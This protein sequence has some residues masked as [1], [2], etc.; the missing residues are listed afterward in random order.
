MQLVN[1][2]AAA[3]QHF[4]RHRQ[5]AHTKVTEATE[6]FRFVAASGHTVLRTSKM[7]HLVKTKHFSR[8]WPCWKDDQMTDQPHE[9]LDLFHP[10]LSI[11]CVLWLVMKW[12]LHRLWYLVKQCCCEAKAQGLPCLA[13]NCVNTSSSR[14]LIISTII[15]PVITTIH[16]SCFLWRG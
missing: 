6:C 3:A 8:R 5:D 13:L 10:V 4:Q 12:F 11:S 7:K 2:I 16:C 14:L 15:T 9:G 1:H